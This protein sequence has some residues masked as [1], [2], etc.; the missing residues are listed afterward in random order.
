MLLCLNMVGPLGCIES[1]FYLSSN[2]E[3]FSSWMSSYT[4]V[5]HFFKSFGEARRGDG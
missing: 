1:V 5:E 2:K 3:Y 4:N